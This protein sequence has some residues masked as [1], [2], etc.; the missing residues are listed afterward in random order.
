MEVESV[1]ELGGPMDISGVPGV[2]PELE[3]VGGVRI[4]GVVEDGAGFIEYGEG[5]GEAGG[6]PGGA[7]LEPG[8]E[9]VETRGFG[10]AVGCGEVEERAFFRAWDGVEA[11]ARQAKTKPERLRE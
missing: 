2:D 11:Q 7:G 1:A 6:V 9:A 3:A 4:G 8:S 10:E 5:K